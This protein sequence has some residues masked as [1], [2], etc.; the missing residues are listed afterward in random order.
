MRRLMRPKVRH[1]EHGFH[2]L[3]VKGIEPMVQMG[4]LEKL[5]TGADTIYDRDRSG[6]EVAAAEGGGE[7]VVTLT[8]EL[9]T[10]LSTATEE[11]LEAVAVPWSQTE[12]FGRRAEPEAL[13]HFL[14][15]LA[16]LARIAT[17]AGNRL[18]CW[19]CL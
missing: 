5:L 7:F 4:T 15:E 11:Q 18:Y 3:S 13:A 17:E 8:D 19:V 1:S 2:A 12:E 9:Q 16:L 10:A 14:R 6:K